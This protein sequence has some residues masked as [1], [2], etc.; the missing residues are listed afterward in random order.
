MHSIF[1]Y[2]QYRDKKALKI[3]YSIDH[4]NYSINFE[5]H[6]RHAKRWELLEGM[7]VDLLIELHFDRK[8]TKAEEATVLSRYRE[9]ISVRE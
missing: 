2:L 4:D 5:Q 6:S 1:G 3:Q 7:G 8:L 9:L